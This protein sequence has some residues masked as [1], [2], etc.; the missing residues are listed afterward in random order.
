MPDVLLLGGKDAPIVE[1][2]HTPAGH[3]VPARG[4]PASDDVLLLGGKEAPVHEPKRTVSDRL[5][6]GRPISRVGW[7]MRRYSFPDKGET[8]AKPIV[9]P[10]SAGYTRS[11]I[12]KLLLRKK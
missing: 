5:A 2:A 11:E 7:I 9:K 12:E 10:Q 1:G 8:G 3:H 4:K 6:R